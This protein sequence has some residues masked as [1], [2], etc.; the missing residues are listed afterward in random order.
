[1]VETGLFHH[2]HPHYIEAGLT[3][4]D[5]QVRKDA[6]RAWENLLRLGRFDYLDVE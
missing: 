6:E 4:E 1:M 3:A 2:C 5:T